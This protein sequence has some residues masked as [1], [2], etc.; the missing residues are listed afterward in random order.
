[1]YIYRCDI[2]TCYVRTTPLHRIYAF[3]WFIKR[4]TADV[5]Y[6]ASRQPEVIQR[7][8][9]LSS[10]SPAG[11][12]SA[13]TK[14]ESSDAQCKDEKWERALS[15]VSS[16]GYILSCDLNSRRK[17]LVTCVSVYLPAL[18]EYLNDKANRKK[19]YTEILFIT[20]KFV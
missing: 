13:N 16:S 4:S 18:A 17:S 12:L 10:A 1:M 11:L 2:Q 19:A 7:L 6:C 3:I 14:I 20:N 8:I 9:R 5:N 15:L